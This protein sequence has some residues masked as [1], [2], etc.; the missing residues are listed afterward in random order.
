[1]T[2]LEQSEKLAGIVTDI[3]LNRE[4]GWSEKLEKTI[5]SFITANYISKQ[6][7]REA[8]ERKQISVCSRHQQATRNCDICGSTFG[9]NQALDDLIKE[10]GV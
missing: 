1:M 9:Y 6:A 2:D 7:L 10:L 8:V 5:Q 3:I 4:G